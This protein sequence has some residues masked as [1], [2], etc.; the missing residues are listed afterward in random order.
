MGLSMGARR[1]SSKIKFR[2]RT[3]AEKL[4]ER[5]TEV[6]NRELRTLFQAIRSD[7]TNQE[8]LDKLKSTY[9]K[10]T[11][12]AGTTGGS[13]GKKIRNFVRD[14]NLNLGGEESQDQPNDS[15]ESPE[16][17]EETPTGEDSPEESEEKAVDLYG[18]VKDAANKITAQ[19]DQPVKAWQD[20]AKL[21]NRLAG[22]SNAN[23]EKTSDTGQRQELAE[24]D[25][26]NEE[27]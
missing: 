27:T 20:I 1:V 8:L 22:L 2:N 21:L 7:P 14:N 11:A 17:A 24:G 9:E 26:K 4:F 13:N 5:L 23:A 12:R 15:E 6:T 10:V 18:A 3:R 19:S 16:D 25:T